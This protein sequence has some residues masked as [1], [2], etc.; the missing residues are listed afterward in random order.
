[1]STLWI[2]RH[3]EAER[4]TKHDP[5]RALTERGEADA[6]AAGQWLAGVA[7]PSLLVLA[8]PYRR[9]QQTARA[10]MAA[11]PGATL[12]TVDWLTPDFDPKQSLQQ[13]ALFPAQQ[14]LLVSHQPLVSS[15]TGLLIAGVYSAGPP[16]GTAS[17][18]EL[19][20]PQ[21]A[22]GCATLRSL[23]HAPNYQI[24]ERL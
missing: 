7:A 2:L 18:A 17:L 16:L 1:M 10:A 21:M 22:S 19:E 14:L 6:R 8:S 15:L 23:R 9:A 12:T 20:L 3:G 24:S 5:D 13:L 4:H 11:L